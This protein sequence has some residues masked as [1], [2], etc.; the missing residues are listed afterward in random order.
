[1]TAEMLRMA[2]M[3]LLTSVVAPALLLLTARHLP[4]HRV[5]APPLLVL[6]GFVLLHGLVVV[7]S[8]GHHLAAGADLA[9][10][11]GLLLAAM[12]F[13]LPVLG[14]GRRLPDALRS[15]YLF[16][17]G[18]ALDLAAIYVIIIGHSAAGLAMIVGMLPIPLAAIGITWRWITREEHA[19][20]A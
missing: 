11:A 2:G 3:G 14:P 1:M 17:A 8:A 5:P 18:P 7:V 19:W 20:S 16:V 6:T 12:V 13:W 10:H 9:L 15:V 4:W